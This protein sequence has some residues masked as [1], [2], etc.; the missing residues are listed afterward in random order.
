M[1][2]ALRQEFQVSLEFLAPR[3]QP[4]WRVPKGTMAP[5]AQ[6]VQKETKAIQEVKGIPAPQAPR[7]TQGPWEVAGNSACLKI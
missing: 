6:L 7:V 2:V 4:V 3:V 5:R 1:E